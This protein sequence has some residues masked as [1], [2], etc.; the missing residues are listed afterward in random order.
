MLRSLRWRAVAVFLGILVVTLATLGFVL[1]DRARHDA[2]VA[3]EERVAVEARAIAALSL[4]SLESAAPEDAL[5]AAAA[6][7]L[8]PGSAVLVI[9]S[10]GSLI[11]ASTAGEH[12]ASFRA[13]EIRTA[14]EEGRT[15]L[16]VRPNPVTSDS[17][18]NLAVPV[19]A[20]GRVVAAVRVTA[21]RAP[22]GEAVG[23]VAATLAI[24]G[25]S[26]LVAGTLLLLWLVAPLVSGLAALGSV[27]R[28]LAAG[29]LYERVET[30]PLS[31]AHELSLAINDMAESLEK[32]V[33]TS[34]QERDIFGA[35]IDGM[36]DALLVVDDEG[37]VALANPA[38]LELFAPGEGTVVGKRLMEVTRDH[39]I[40]RIVADALREGR[41]QSGKVEYG[42][43]LR[44]LHVLVTPIEEKGGLSALV[45][46]QDLTE[47]QRLEAVRRD[48]VANVSH[49]LRTPLAS[50]K[51]AAE[52]IQ[53]G[54]LDDVQTTREFLAR[55]DV[56]VDHM[57]QMVQR[58]LD[59]SRLETGKAQ[60]NMEA[61]DVKAL[62][63][64]ATDRVRPQ[65]ESRG[66]A[67]TVDAPEGM[68]PVMADRAAV[69]EIMLNLIDN[70]MRFTDDG[71]I[72]VSAREVDAGVEVT[73]EDSGPGILPEDLPHIFERFY[74][75]DRSRSSGGAGLG[76]ALAKHTVQ[77][78]GGEI[79][80]E[81]PPGKGAIVHFTLPLAAV[82]SI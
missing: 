36:A 60:F 69:Q 49:E 52:A 70:A 58:L 33:R 65:A 37:S 53:G 14:L 62:L 26:T 5:A 43:D 21:S 31:E 56:E 51:A 1:G 47:V 41:H 34:Y 7:I 39:E 72:L 15:G 4:S 9:G 13:P 16:A 77:A 45:M 55:I 81:S 6:A 8:A 74:K 19:V 68:A 18:L 71:S 50:I 76:L 57:A 79:W 30:V 40:G 48:F 27:A 35:V 25:A 82:A 63:D 22:L 20:D 12:G 3:L 10:D 78:H 32:Q 67:L 38:A 66:L 11:Y 73:V 80:A 29:Q 61:L 24:A 64:E 44:L 17:E 54:A 46:I 28:R 23:R 2:G 59:L 75:A 42:P